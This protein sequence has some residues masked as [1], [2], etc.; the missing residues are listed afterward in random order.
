MWKG[1][2]TC[3]VA[4]L[5]STGRRHQRYYNSQDHMYKP[6]LPGPLISDI[7]NIEKSMQIH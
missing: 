2:Q 6:Q 7:T 4:R 3:V 1:Q 5:T